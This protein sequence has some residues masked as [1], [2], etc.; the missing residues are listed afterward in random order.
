MSNK[1]IGI[2]TSGGDCGG[3]NAAIRSIFY[4]AKNKYNMDVFVIKDGTAGLMHRPVSAIK[5]NHKILCDLI[6]RSLHN[7]TLNNEKLNI[8]QSKKQTSYY[9]SILFFEHRLL[10]ENILI[11]LIFGSHYIKNQIFAFENNKTPQKHVSILLENLIIQISNLAIIKLIENMQSLSATIN[12]LIENK[13]CNSSYLSIR[14]IALF[15]NNLILQ[16]L[17]YIFFHQPKAIYN[18]RY[19]IWLLSS[20]GLISK[21][22]YISRLDDLYKVSKLKRFL[23]LLLEV[24]D[25]LMPKLEQLLLLLGKIILYILIK[26]LGNS[27]IFIIRTIIISLQNKH[28][29]K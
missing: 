27:I 26:V 10:L 22:I 24:Q 8:V 9:K 19:K 6:D 12:F 18:A 2:L 25:I 13:L 1:R 3:L 17:L 28:K 5:L 23:I 7:F 4:R 29:Y 11:Y 14:S 16:N 21:Y 20:H 15:R